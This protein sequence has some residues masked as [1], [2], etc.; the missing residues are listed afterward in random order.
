MIQKLS[1]S[2]QVEL[3][4]R[5]IQNDLDL[6]QVLESLGL[7]YDCFRYRQNDDGNF[8]FPE[9]E[10]SISLPYKTP[11]D[12]RLQVHEVPAI[13]FFS[14]TGGLEIGFEYAG[15]NSLASI[16]INETFCTTLRRNNKQLTIIGPPDYTGDV[17]NKEELTDILH[18]KIGIHAPFEGVFHGGAPCQPFSIASNQ[19]FSKNGD[20]FK[21]IG[22]QHEEY[23]NLLFDFIWYIQKFKP[24][25]FLIENVVGL[26]T[27]DGGQ[28]I[29]QA[30]RT[31]EKSGYKTVKCVV[32]AANYEVPQYR[33]RLFIVGTAGSKKEFHFP[34]KAPGAVSC[35]KAL[36]KPL[37]DVANHVKRKHKAQ[38]VIRYMDLRYGERDKLGRVDRLNPCLPSKTVIAGGSKGGGRSH[39]HPR[40]PRTLTVR[41]SARLQTFPDNYVFYGSPARQ[42]TQVGNA[43]PPLLALKIAHAIYETVYHR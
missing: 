42:F 26:L 8:L 20:N 21:R 38:S 27:M 12:C 14:G 6:D 32:N 39:L 3:L 5:C 17:R 23:G 19:R 43:V 36:E 22:F 28:Q 18:R 9:S 2:E 16:E 34:S 24:R 11:E 41:E 15:F 30:I 37:K 35:D 33:Q 4:Q 10:R 25:I 31:L 40:I 7:E 29:E 1:I 13:G